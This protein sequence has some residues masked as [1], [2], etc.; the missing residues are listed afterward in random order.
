MKLSGINITLLLGKVKPEP[1]PL[2]IMEALESVE[3]SFSDAEQ[4]MIRHLAE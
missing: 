3:V 4:A 2:H 1:A